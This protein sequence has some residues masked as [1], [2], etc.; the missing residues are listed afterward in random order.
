[1]LYSPSLLVLET[2]V[3]RAAVTAAL[4][5]LLPT[6][7]RFV[8][9][10]GFAGALDPALAVGDVLLADTIVDETRQE[11]PATWP[12]SAPPSVRGGRLLTT[13]GLV[14]TVDDKQRLG[15]QYGAIAVDMEAAFAAAVC[16][17]QE[18]PFGCIRAISDAADAPLSPALLSL[19]TG[20][21]VS[22]TRVFGAVIRK[23]T[24]VRELL[25]LGRDTRLAARRL[26]ECLNEISKL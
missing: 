12:A 21:R 19:L 15:T 25:R 6:R 17:D 26:A 7:P 20:G 13:A 2:G 1:M 14:A 4:D 16:A 5:W 8:L 9:Y 22:A 11:W 24:L 18:I 10:A 3:G 23:P